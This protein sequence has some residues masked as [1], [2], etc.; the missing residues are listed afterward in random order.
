MLNC[1]LQDLFRNTHLNIFGALKYA[2]KCAKLHFFHD[3][4]DE[5]V[6]QAH[7]KVCDFE[8]LVSE[9][10]MQTDNAAVIQR[11]LLEH[12]NSVHLRYSRVYSLFCCVFFPCA[13]SNFN[14]K[15]NKITFIAAMW[16]HSNFCSHFHFF[17]D[18]SLLEIS[19]AECLR[20]K[21]SVC[22]GPSCAPQAALETA[23]YQITLI[24]SFFAQGG[25][26]R[27]SQQGLH[28]NHGLYGH[29]G[30]QDRQ[31]NQVT[32]KRQDRQISYLKLTFQATS[33]GQLSQFLRCLGLSPKSLTPHPPRC[34]M[35]HH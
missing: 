7:Y 11:L 13:P 33:E 14:N 34:I 29:H 16:P 1:I 26:G 10:K 9:R 22:S 18:Q 32:W 30:N 15:K 12:L 2:P 5:V 21:V 20:S 23:R 8:K 35:M 3:E 31:D 4:T 19:L 17:D 6:Q 28:G 24:L 27:H 25:P